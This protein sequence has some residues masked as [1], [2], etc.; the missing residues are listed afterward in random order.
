MIDEDFLTFY[1]LSPYSGNSFAVQKLFIWYNPTC[2]FLLF[3]ELLESY[4]ESCCLCLYLKVF[5]LVV[6]KFQ[7]YIK[8]FDHILN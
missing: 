3:S 1:R 6:S 8:V 4:S 7:V 5:S 2:Q